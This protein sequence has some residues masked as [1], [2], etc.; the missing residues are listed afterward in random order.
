MQKVHPTL[1]QL[2][3]LIKLESL[4]TELDLLSAGDG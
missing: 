3:L 4:F 2:R 1:N